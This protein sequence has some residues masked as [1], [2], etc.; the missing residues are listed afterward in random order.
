M[1]KEKETCAQRSCDTIKIVLGLLTEI[2]DYY[3][4]L[5]VHIVQLVISERKEEAVQCF[6]DFF[7]KK[8][9]VAEAMVSSYQIALIVYSWFSKTIFRG[10][11]EP[12]KSLKPWLN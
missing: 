5:E 4:E 1:K 8:K 2:H 9:S 10:I 6:I 12:S 3:P 7:G 11:Y